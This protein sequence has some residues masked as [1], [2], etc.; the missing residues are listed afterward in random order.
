ML[1]G[2]S[3]DPPSEWGHRYF[4]GYLN[5]IIQQANCLLGI[6]HKP[7]SDVGLFD[8]DDVPQNS[9]VVLMLAQYRQ[10]QF[11]VLD[12]GFDFRPNEYI[13]QAPD[14]SRAFYQQIPRN[15]V[16]CI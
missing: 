16:G 4:L 15:Q 3:L 5:Q 6:A 12:F 2:V 8:E 10:I 11:P 1:A 9:D 7:F 14:C 13:R